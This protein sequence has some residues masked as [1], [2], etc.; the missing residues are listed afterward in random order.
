MNIYEVKQECSQYY[1]NLFSI[2]IFF[3]IATFVE[4]IGESSFY[5]F[6]NQT[7]N[8]LLLSLAP[9]KDFNINESIA[10]HAAHDFQCECLS[11]K[12]IFINCLLRQCHT[13]FGIFIQQV[14]V[15]ILS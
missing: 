12:G 3:K 6:T 9:V 2:I 4:T 13:I 5:G 15:S 7:I 10:T 8:S 14:N 1:T 11:N